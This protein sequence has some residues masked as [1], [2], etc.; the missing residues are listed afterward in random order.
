MLGIDGTGGGIVER[1]HSHCRGR[2][3]AVTAD[4]DLSGA[5][6]HSFQVCRARLLAL[7]RVRS[8]RPDLV[9]L[10]EVMPPF[11]DGLDVCR[12][13]RSGRTRPR[14]GH[15]RQRARALD[16]PADRGGPSRG[17]RG[18]V[19]G[20]RG[21]RVH[22]GAAGPAGRGRRRGAGLAGGARPVVVQQAVLDPARD[23]RAVVADVRPR[24]VLARHP[25]VQ[26]EAVG[27][28][29]PGRA[30]RTRSSGP[31]G[32]S[33]SSRWCCRPRCPCWT[34]RG[35]RRRRHLPAR[36]RPPWPA[37]RGR[38]GRDGAEGHR[39]ELRPK[40]HRS[41]PEL[42]VVPAGRCAG[43]AGRFVRVR[44]KNCPEG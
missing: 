42:L 15:R 43:R 23:A 30:R 3:K 1:A 27:S 14:A 6:G 26:G 22:G 36:P 18:G 5:G 34:S 38:R 41:S 16:R 33:R 24:A 31:S 40:T 37:V 21:V 28:P 35:C 13:L 17:R 10:E 20:G 7:E 32:C 8:V 12:I 2:R 25:A 44:R 11:V 39:G 29:G 9:V 19:R 4:S